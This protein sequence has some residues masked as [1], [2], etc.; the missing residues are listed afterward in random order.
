MSSIKVFVTGGSG[1]VGT[2]V[3]KSLVSKGH[4]VT[5]LARSD[6]SA[7][8]VAGLGAKLV[9]GTQTDLDVL[10]AAAAAAD[11]VIHL[12]YNHEAMFRG[13][14]AQAFAE[15]AAA[16]DALAAPLVGTGKALCVASGVLG[17][18]GADEYAIKEHAGRYLAELQTKAYAARGVHATVVRLAPVVHGPGKEHAFITIPA[19]VARAMSEAAYVGDGANAWAAVHVDDAAE[20]FV[21][22]ATTRGA[23]AGATLNGVDEP[24]FTTRRI[25]EFIGA[26]LGVPAKSISKQDAAARWPVMI[27][28]VMTEGVPISNDKTKA[29]LGWKPT[30]PGL[31]EDLETYSCFKQ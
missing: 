15:D 16:I 4:V 25:T 2:A 7:A 1:H 30:G 9:R 27:A 22:A 20:L 14:M 18:T 31:F 28:W 5:A 24:G 13:E 29:W 6:A 17:A 23:P 19:S 21:L 12:S 3:I 10:S 26:K 8:Y 11:A